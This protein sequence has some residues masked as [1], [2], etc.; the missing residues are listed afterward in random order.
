MLKKFGGE[1]VVNNIN[2]CKNCGEQLKAVVCR[3][4]AYDSRQG[5]PIAPK[6][7]ASQQS[8]APNKPNQ[9]ADFLGKYKDF[10]DDEQLVAA[11]KMF[12]NGIVG[13]KDIEAAKGFLLTSALK[14][15]INSM[16]ILGALFEESDE[17]QAI[18]WYLQAAKLGNIEAQNILMHKVGGD[19]QTQTDKEIFAKSGAS[20]GTLEQLVDAVRPFCVRF[21]CSTP[22][23]SDGARG[24]GC[25]VSSKYVVTNHHVVY[26]DRKKAF[27]KDIEIMFHPSISNSK[28][29]VEIVCVDAKNDIAICELQSM[30]VKTEGFPQFADA[31]SVSVG[32]EVFTYGNPL[33]R[34]LF[35]SCGTIARETEKGVYGYGEVLHTN[36]SIN[37]GNSGG[38]LFD[39]S[40]NLIGLMTSVPKDYD[41][42]AVYGMSLATTSN[43]ILEL[44]RKNNLKL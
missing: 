15:N 26:N 25:I 38:A 5:I 41:D 14:G 30:A 27:Y 42:K 13:G 35:L 39:Y 40:G 17:S 44:A 6:S 8:T 3:Y 23:K 32:Q 43:S 2:L 31:H 12:A 4:C 11:A 33:G 10:M 20:A 1:K 22:N 21:F 19:L 7:P 29:R 37:G 9:M 16:L 36:M 34:G 24:S 28:N 18:W